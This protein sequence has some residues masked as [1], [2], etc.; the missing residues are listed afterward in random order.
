M[1][2]E[3]R[4]TCS[5]EHRP[6]SLIMAVSLLLWLSDAHANATDA[7]LPERGTPANVIERLTPAS[8]VSASVSHRLAYRDVRDDIYSS[9]AWTSGILQAPAHKW[10][11]RIDLEHTKA[12]TQ[13]TPS[14][15]EV[16]WTPDAEWPSPVESNR[17]DWRPH[18]RIAKKLANGFLWGIIP[19]YSVGTML[20]LSSPSLATSLLLDLSVAFGYP[21]GVAIGVSRVDPHDRLTMS[22]MGSLAGLAANFY[23]PL[24]YTSSDTHQFRAYDWDLIWRWFVYPL[25]G[26]TVASEL[27]RNPPE[28]QSLSIALKPALKGGLSPVVKWRF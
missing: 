15:L 12:V 1:H 3:R 25:L 22:T 27:W 18:K 13:A 16:G 17:D 5:H 6:E 26:A 7:P 10:S 20:A 4:R 21:V 23:L 11:Q 28:V 14:P 9:L 19:S 24:L 2:S 8:G